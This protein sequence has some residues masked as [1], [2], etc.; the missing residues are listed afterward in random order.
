MSN[1]S[2]SVR[3]VDSNWRGANMSSRHMPGQELPEKRGRCSKDFDLG[4][5]AR[6]HGLYPVAVHFQDAAG[7][8]N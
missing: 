5:G 2:N 8:W 7:R 3:P 6:Q 1:I 4:R